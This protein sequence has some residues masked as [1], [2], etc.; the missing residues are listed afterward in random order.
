MNIVD[1]VILICFVPALIRGISRGFVEQALALVGLVAGIWAAI[2][3]YLPFQESLKP[4]ITIDETAMKVA[5]FALILIVV[6]LAAKLIALLVKRILK[7]VLLGWLD[8]LLG[9]LFAL[10][11]AL[12]IIG[13][14]IVAMHT[15]NARFQLVDSPVFSQS[16]LYNRILDGAYSIF[17]AL[18]DFLHE[19]AD[20]A[21]AAAE[22]AGSTPVSI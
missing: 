1:I 8:K 4:Y 15:V 7:F 22:T 19:A 13:L 16:L 18:K 3:Y 6:V 9:I 12:V 14:V 21:K 20:A 2:H 5:S 17:P 10:G 11:V